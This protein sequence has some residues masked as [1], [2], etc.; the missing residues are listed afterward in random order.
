MFGKKKML[1]YSDEEMNSLI[2][3]SS[4]KEETR[5]IV[6]GL[7][8]PPSLGDHKEV[9]NKLLIGLVAVIFVSNG[10]AIYSMAMGW[11]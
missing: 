7:L 3:D 2:E 6:S 10:L 5:R 4:E 11:I 8:T 1:T 9:S